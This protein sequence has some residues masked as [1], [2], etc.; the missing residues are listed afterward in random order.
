RGDITGALVLGGGV[1]IFA[2]YNGGE[3]LVNNATTDF[4]GGNDRV[5]NFAGSVIHLQNGAIS[6]GA[7]NAN[8]FENSGIIR[9][10]GY[11]L[12]DMGNGLPLPVGPGAPEAVPSLNTLPFVNDGLITFLDGSPDDMLT[13]I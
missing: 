5:Y 3:W 2:G 4:G 11:G 10:S 6:L 12:I 8:L 13:V 7:G 1:D 9:V